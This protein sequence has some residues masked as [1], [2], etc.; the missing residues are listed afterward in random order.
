MDLWGESLTIVFPSFSLKMEIVVVRLHIYGSINLEC[1]TNFQE[2]GYVS[3]GIFI[4]WPIKLHKLLHNLN[5]VRLDLKI[6]S[7]NSWPDYA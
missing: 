7:C 6:V 3:I 4:L 1:V 5:E 2:I